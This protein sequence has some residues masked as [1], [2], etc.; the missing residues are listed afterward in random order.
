MEKNKTKPDIRFKGFTDDWEQRKFNELCDMVTVG[1]ANSATHAYSDSGI[2]MFRNQNIKPNFLDDTDIIHIKPEFEVKYKNKRL[3][4]NDLLVA[5]T[6]YPG[7]ACVIPEKYENSQTFTTLIARPKKNVNPYFLCQYLN[8]D[9]GVEY[10][11]STQIGGGQKNSSA[12]IL[13]EMPV[14]LP[15]DVEEEKRIA[16]Y[17]SQLDN[18]I[19]LHQRECNQLKELKKTMLKKMFPRDGSNIP[20]VRFAG[21][22]D[23]WEQCKFLELYEKNTERNN[24]LIG[25][26]RTISIATMSYKD[27]GN[28]ASDSS[29]KTY[30]V[31]RPGDLAF[32]GHTNKEFRYGRFVANDIGIGI[33]SPRF[34]TL[35][36]IK[37]MPID[38]WKYYIH[39][40]PIMR[41]VL[42]NSTKAG[43]MMNELVVDDFMKQAVFVPS[44]SEQQ[45]LGQ[46]FSQLDN[47]ITLHQRL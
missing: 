35:R 15:S 11:E 36:P 47:L 25:Y 20:E 4:K 28:G 46:Y 45:H 42:V 38:F 37:K 22:T 19:T 9:V 43:T 27:E 6:G 5:R 24:K 12:R 1:I 18:L 21:F 10:F 32:E 7:T 13:N 41:K 26:D 3:K 23:V 30:K 31:L 40:E 2:V 33:M 14:T 39:Y 16:D 29:L 44:I 8:S 17:F 34:S